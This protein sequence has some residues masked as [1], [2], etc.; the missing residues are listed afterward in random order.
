MLLKKSGCTALWL[1]SAIA[2]FAQ[3]SQESVFSY[4]NS[5]YESWGLTHEDISDLRITDSHVSS[6]SGATHFYLQQFYHDIPVRALASV[7]FNADGKVIHETQSL[8]AN[9]SQKIKR[10]LPKLTAQEA[11]IA[12]AKILNLPISNQLKTL[13]SKHF[14]VG[15]HWFE[16]TEIS[17]KPISVSLVYEINERGNLILC[18][19]MLIHTPDF[20]N[21][22]ELRLDAISGKEVG[23][24]NRMVKCDFDCSHS[25]QN[26]QST[27]LDLETRVLTDNHLHLKVKGS[28]KQSVLNPVSFEGHYRAFHWP[29]ESPLYGNRSLKAGTQIA[30]ST[31]SPNGW[32][33]D[34][35]MAY[36]HTRGNNAFAVY[37]PNGPPA[38]GL[39]TTSAIT[40]DPVTGTYISGNVPV[41]DT[42]LRFN[43]FNSLN[44]TTGTAFIEFALTN[45]FVWNN[46]CHDVFY[47]YGFDEAAG[48]FQ[49]TNTS[50]MGTGSDLV[51]AGAQDG[52]NTNQAAFVR[53]AEGDYPYMKMHLWNT[54]LPDSILDSS[55][56]NLVVVH[57]YVHGVTGRLLGGGN[58]ISCFNG[59]EHGDEGWS[60]FFG[61]MLTM[62]D[63]DGDGTLEENV[64]REGIRGI[65]NY[66]RNDDLSGCTSTNP[67]DTCGLRPTAYTTD[68]TIN[69]FT[70]GDVPNMAVPHGVG[71]VWCSMLWEMT[72]KLI[73]QYGFEP[74]ITKT[75]STAGNI[76]AMKLVMEGIKMT[77]CGISALNF[78]EMRDAIFAADTA[79]YGGAN[80]NLI[81]E[82]FAKRGL[83][84]SAT[85]GGN[86]AFDLPTI[87]TQKRVD[88]EQAEI[89]E[90]ITYSITVQNNH[91]ANLTNV[92]VTDI[93]PAHLMV[94]NIS[95][96][97]TNSGGTITWNLGTIAVNASDSVNFTATIQNSA[98]T[99]A[100]LFENDLENSTTEFVPG[101]LW[102]WVDNVPAGAHSGDR[103]WEHAGYSTVTEG[104][105]VLSLT[106][107]G[108][109]NNHLSFWQDL[110]TETGFDGG[111]IEYL[112]GTEWKDLSTRIIKN[113]YNG[114]L[115][116]RLPIGL[117]TTTLA[118][119]RAYTGIT[120]GYF[121]TI[122]DLSG[123][124]GSSQ[125][126]FRFATD[127]SN[128]A[129]NGSNPVLPFGWRLDD[130][131]LLDF[132]NIENEAC[133]TATGQGFSD[134]G[135]VGDVGT[136]VYATGAL[137]I[138]LLNFQ[139]TGREKDILLN[140]STAFETNFEGFEVQRSL[141]TRNWKSIGWQTAQNANFGASNYQ[142][143]DFDVQLNQVYYYRL[144]QLDLDGTFEYSKIV[145]AQIDRKEFDV[146]IFP[147]PATE[148]L[149]IVFGNAFKDPLKI[150]LINP[151]GQKVKSIILEANTSFH[152]LNIKDL[153]PQLYF[154][155]ISAG[156][157]VII[158]KVTKKY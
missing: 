132:S 83:G 90:S 66:L 86:E 69:P 94:T 125:I 53:S 136:I 2:I 113:G 65:G 75:T 147:N 12:S 10:T 24:E 80:Y 150:E 3:I 100:I 129:Y 35:N 9:I 115:S 106:L 87:Y 62:Q 102:Q 119:R 1:L 84:V 82:A 111:V 77:P 156:R 127:N 31:A 27:G 128:S 41:P 56:D 5:R 101:G 157:K 59:T 23:R 50:G 7:H 45:L 26:A 34:T 14:S 21:V 70:Y 67:N 104:S 39:P 117:P 22:W 153:A 79:L 11:V 126:R 88:K 145:S 64:I 46:I 143:I 138:E 112:S 78:I 98:D 130:F 20:Q 118:G 114:G 144:K 42:L 16:S 33:D 116:G 28:Q 68:M 18:W 52:T 40:R 108:S 105:L 97:G 30:D 13:D 133:A 76:R 124:S 123:F 8:I 95:S 43:Y 32:H 74:D 152:S 134:C 103:F 140:W 109:K 158:R 141:D 55:F 71:F 155:K 48:N 121:Q 72:W 19:E 4:I 92:S 37:L 142:F 15:K 57:E 91:T 151:N 29:L 146:K 60:D 38:V 17:L 99:T 6:V 135:D 61:L 44:S 148:V 110:D 36:D 120:N 54:A 96:G 137:P 149:N 139:A 85:A 107:D 49:E 93:V 131:Q 154:L 122:I 47:L 58:T 89:G 63:F 73:N 81:W 25:F 51:L